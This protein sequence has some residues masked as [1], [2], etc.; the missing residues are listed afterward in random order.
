M[1]LV[2]SSQTDDMGEGVLAQT[3]VTEFLATVRKFGEELSL[4]VVFN[5]K[6]GDMGELVVL[7]VI[8]LVEKPIGEETEDYIVVS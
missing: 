6:V 8:G 5:T 3:I 2:L 4:L 7:K 1:G